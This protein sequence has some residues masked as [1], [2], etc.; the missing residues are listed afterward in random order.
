MVRT[1]CKVLE[2]NFTCIHSFHVHRGVTQISGTKYLE[3]F[4]YMTEVILGKQAV[5]KGAGV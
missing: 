1:E 2:I 5:P 4:S 3:D